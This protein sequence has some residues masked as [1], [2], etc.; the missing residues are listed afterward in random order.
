MYLYLDNVQMWVRWNINDTFLNKNMKISII[1]VCKN[2]SESLEITIRSILSQDY[3]DYEYIIIDSNSKDETGKII[4]KYQNEFATKKIRFIFLSET[5][6]GIYD[7]MNKGIKLAFGE[8]INFMNAGDQF[9]KSNVLSN[10]FKDDTKINDIV[11]VYGYKYHRGKPHYP[12]SPKILKLGLIMANHQSM[13][14]NKKVLKED[15]IYDLKYPIYGDYELVNRLYLKYG[16][17][18]FKYLSTP[19]AIYEGGGISEKPSYQK[20]KDKYLILLRH[21]GVFGVFKGLWYKLVKSN[22]QNWIS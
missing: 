4:E 22:R 21:Y 13:F 15:M 18:K 3:N 8:W 1:T 16:E 10:V 5:D 19:I 20:R 2:A 14:F 12:L 11:L 9:Y 7:A 17:R 6:K